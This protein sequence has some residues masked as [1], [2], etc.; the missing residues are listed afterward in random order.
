LTLADRDQPSDWSVGQPPG[1]PSSCSGGDA[2]DTPSERTLKAA[3]SA[4]PESRRSSRCSLRRPRIARR[5]PPRGEIHGDNRSRDLRASAGTAEG[6]RASRG[7]DAAQGACRAEAIRADPTWQNAL[8]KRASTISRSWRSTPSQ[9]AASVKTSTSTR[10]WFEGS[11]TCGAIRA[12]TATRGRSKPSEIGW[13]PVRADDLLSEATIARVDDQESRVELRVTE[14]H[15]GADRQV[16][17]L[18]VMLLIE[19]AVAPLLGRPT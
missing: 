18:T 15:L 17:R 9:R 16:S 8:Q 5:H 13:R 1:G 4:G 7:H 10:G 12:T 6:R 11:P 2:T 19:R 14:E 3:S